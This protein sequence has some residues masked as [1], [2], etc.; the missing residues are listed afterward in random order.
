MKTKLLRICFVVSMMSSGVA[1]GQQNL[2]YNHY[3]INPFLYNPS[4]I[5][6]NGYT[7]LYLNYRKQ[8]S[9]IEGAPTTATM[10][11]HLPL[12]YKTGIAVSAMQDE[13]GLLKT[14]KGLVS[15]SYQIYL[16][17][18]I[19]DIHKISFGLS[20]GVTNSRI[21]AED[22]DDQQ[23]PVLGNNTSS[24]D[25]QFGFHYQYN[26]FKIGFALPTIFETRIASEEGF[27]KPGNTQLD[28]MI[29][30]VSYDFK[31]GPR[32][33]F[34]PMFTY[35][36]FENL[37]PQ[38]EGL[39]SVKLSNVG[40]IGGAYRQDYGATGFF[41][42]NIKDKYKVGYAYEFAT[43]QADKIGTGTH[44]IQ[45]I[46][47]LGKRHH[48]KPHAAHKTPEPVVAHQTPPAEEK[49]QNNSIDPIEDEKTEPQDQP[50]QPVTRP[51]VEK[52]VD[53][54]VKTTPVEVKPEPVKPEPVKRD[55]VIVEP[56]PEPVK[57]KPIEAPVKSLDG[58]NLTPGHYVI[59]GAF[60]NETNAKNFQN[61]LKKSGYPAHVAFHPAKGY[62][63][64]HMDNVGS[65]ED[66]RAMRDKYRQM[67][68]YSF[69]DTWILTIE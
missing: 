65:L 66:A 18:K 68:R 7:E 5:A 38:F 58:G 52:P 40:W 26:N 59:V 60:A 44:E 23:D 9:G 45:V 33:S 32:F 10:N 55:P 47:R 69:R 46:L 2:F 54:P 56:K 4:Y 61:T 41:G 63:V 19:T 20:A 43:D 34:E 51:V 14:T 31:F 24:M 27:N 57:A 12:N 30:S 28:N 17:E 8:W 39:A 25:G 13:A 48:A 1:F 37:D 22:A 36:T 50:A 11:L 21:N 16:G 15:F 6:P 35:R 62:F 3:F 67:S 64:V 29:G 49:P 53:E 42:L